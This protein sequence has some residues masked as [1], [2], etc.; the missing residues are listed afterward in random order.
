MAEGSKNQPDEDDLILEP[1]ED[2]RQ[3][4]LN[5]IDNQLMTITTL[6]DIDGDPYELWN[7]DRIK[8]IVRAMKVIYKMQSNLLK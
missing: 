2:D 8:I 6:M 5:V 1:D 7:E 3:A 4:E